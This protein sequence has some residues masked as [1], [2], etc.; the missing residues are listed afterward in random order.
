MATYSKFFCF[1]EDCSWHSEAKQQYDSKCTLTHVP[2]QLLDL[3]TQNTVS[4]P[5]HNIMDLS[6]LN[7]SF[8]SETFFTVMSRCNLFIVQQQFVHIRTASRCF[9]TFHDSTSVNQPRSRFAI[10]KLLSLR[11]SSCL[12]TIRK[13]ERIRALST[14][15]FTAPF[16]N[17]DR[18][19]LE[20]RCGFSVLSSNS[21]SGSSSFLR[22]FR[23]VWYVTFRLLLRLGEFSF[24]CSDRGAGTRLRNA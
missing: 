3:I 21:S 12:T 16:R 6:V 10:S 24:A 8:Q 19:K 1:V 23:L 17:S 22:I 5:R 9:A 4:I 2:L 14:L 15:Y 20:I 7:F 18:A 13:R 11:D